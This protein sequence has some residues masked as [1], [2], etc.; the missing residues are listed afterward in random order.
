[1]NVLTRAGTLAGAAVLAVTGLADPAS[2]ATGPT[3]A[4]VEQAGYAATGAQFDNVQTSV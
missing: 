4:T 3:I 1:M 2:A